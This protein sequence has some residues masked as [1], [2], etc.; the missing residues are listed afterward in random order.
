MI[1]VKAIDRLGQTGD[2]A[3]IDFFSIDTVP[4]G[5]AA[6][7]SPADDPARDS[8]VN[9]QTPLFDWDASPGDVFGYRLLVASGDFATGPVVIE[10]VITGD[11]T[12]FQVPT[13][14]AGDIRVVTGDVLPDGVY[15][16]RV[17]ARDEARNTATSDTRTFTVDL[18]APGAPVLVAPVNAPA[19]ESFLNTR[20]TFLE[21]SPST[22]DVFD[23][24]LQVT[25]GDID[26]GPFDIAK[27]IT[28][29]VT[30]GEIT[31]SGDGTYQWRVI[32][33]DKA[34]NAATS[35]T[36]IF[37]V[38]IVP[39][40]VPPLRAPA[41]GAFLKTGTPEFDWG[42]SAGDLEDYLLQ[43]VVSGEGFE[44]RPFAIEVVV[45]GDVTRFQV[46]TGDALADA[47]TEYKWR[48][49][50][51]DKAFN[52]ATSDTRTFTVDV[53]PPGTA[54]LISPARN[55]FLNSSTPPFVWQP[56]TEVVE[57]ATGDGVRTE[58][59]LDGDPADRIDDDVLTDADVLVE[60][61]IGTVLT[62]ITD[63][64]VDHTGDTVTFVVAPATGDGA[65]IRFTYSVTGD[66]TA[67]VQ[68]YRLQVVRSGDEF[69][70]GFFVINE[71]LGTKITDTGRLPTAAA[72]DPLADDTYRWRVTARD[73]SLNVT[74]SDART[75][76]VDTVD[77]DLPALVAPAQGAFVNT[78]TPLL[79]WAPI[80]VQ[81]A[82]GDGVKRTFAL[83]GDPVDRDFD[84]ILTDADVLVEQPIGILLT[85]TD[86]SVDHTGDTVTFVVAPGTGGTP[87]IVRF[88]FVI[89]DN[90]A[91][92]EDYLL[93]VTSG[94]GDIS[95]GPFEI[96]KEITGDTTQFQV[97]T[98]DA[99]TYSGRTYQWRVIARDKAFNAATSDTQVFVVDIVGPGAPPLVAPVNAPARGSFLNTST[100]LFVWNESDLEVKEYL[101]RVTSGDIN[102]GDVVIDVVI[103]T[104]D[105]TEFQV[106]TADP[107]ADGRYEWR[108]TARDRAGNTA[109][110]LDT[111]TFT[112]DTEAP[113][114]PALVAPAN[115]PVRASFLNTSTPLFDWAEPP[116]TG[117]VEDYLLQV[118]SGATFTAPFDIGEVISGDTTEFQVPAGTALPEAGTAYRWRVI[119]R[120]EAF[121]AGTS[122]IRTFT[123]DTDAPVPPE[124]VS[125]ADL[126]ATGSF[127]NTGGVFF[128]WSASQTP[129]D[130]EEYLLQV[131]LSGDE[132]RIGSFARFKTADA[133]TTELQLQTADLL[134][135]AAYEWRVVAQ[136]LA[137]NTASSVTRT[138]KVDTLPPSRPQNLEEVTVD[139]RA[140]ARVFEWDPSIDP[141][142]PPPG[143]TGDESG[144]KFYNVE[145]RG[146][147][148]LDIK[149][150]DP[151]IR[152]GDLVQFTTPPLVAGSYTIRVQA[153]DAAGNTGDFT[154][155][156]PFDA[157]PKDAVQNLRVVDP[158]FVDTVLG[159]TVS[160]SDPTFRWTRPRELDF[161][162]TTYLV[163]VTGDAFGIPFGPFTGDQFTVACFD[164]DG[165][166]LGT[167][168]QCVIAIDAGDETK[169]T[170]TG[171]VPDGTHKLGVV[172]ID[173]EGNSGPVVE[174]TFT[175]DTKAPGAPVLVVPADQ[176]PPEDP[177]R[178]AFLNTS[179]PFF[180]WNVSTGDVFGYRLRVTS[181]GIATGPV[182]VEVLITGD[183]TEFQLQPRDLAVTLDTAIIRI[184]TGD[185]LLDGVYQWQVIARDRALNLATSDPR[186]FTVDTVAPAPPALLRPSTVDLFNSLTVEFEWVPST[187]DDIFSYRLQVTSGDINLGPFDVDKELFHPT[188]GDRI[189]LSGDGVYQWRVGAQDLAGND[190][191]TGDLEVRSFEVD[192]VP[193][194]PP[195]LL[196]P[197]TGDRFNSR[198][199]EFE[200]APSTSDDIST[201]RLQVTSGDI[202]LGPFQVDKVLSHPTTGDRITLSG[203]EVYKWRVG[204]QDLAGN[205][206]PTGDLEV[207]VFEV[208]TVPPA[209]PALLRPETGDL[210]NSRTVEFEWVPST[211]DDIFSYRLQV[212]TADGDIDAGPL[213]VDKELLHPITGDGITVSGDGVYQWRVIARD[214]ALNTAASVTRTFTVDTTPPAAPA[215][216]APVDRAFENTS[217]PSFDWLASAST[218]DVFGYRLQ[219][220]RFTEASGLGT[221][222]IDVV[223]TGDVVTGDITGF[224]ALTGDST[225]IGVLIGGPL[226]DGRYE[227]HVRARDLAR[228]EVP[229]RDLEVRTFTVDTVPPP[230]PDLVSP[231]D[232]ALVRTRTPLFAWVPN[233]I[234]VSDN[235]LRV[236]SGDITTG[237][238]DLD[239]MV[240]HEILRFQTFQSTGDLADGT[241]RWRVTSRDLALN[242][243]TSDTRTFTVD[244]TPPAA[245]VLVAPADSAFLNTSTTTFRWATGDADD[246]LLQVVVAGDD[247]VKGPFAIS[248]VI[249]G[250][251]TE[252][253]V[254]TGDALAD[255]AYRWRVIAR[256]L[257]LNTASSVTRTFTV[258]T[259]P[260]G[261]PALVEPA[262]GAFLDTG[263]PAFDWKDSTG[264][265]QEYLLRVVVS[266][267]DLNTGP[268]AINVVVATAD[269]TQ[270]Q[271]PTGDA[272]NDATY[273]WRVTARDRALNTAPS[274]TR[275]FV[276]DTITPTRP[277]TAD[278]VT[279]DPETNQFDQNAVV[280]VLQWQRSTDPI[281][282]PPNGTT[283]DESGVNFYN[284]LVTGPQA[285]AGV[286]FHNTCNRGSTGDRCEFVTPEL[287][288]GNYEIRVTAVDT[289][290]N[291]SPVSIGVFRAGPPGVVR[292]L[293]LVAPVF[294]NTVAT[295]DP[296]FRWNPPEL[297][298]QVE[299][300]TYEVATGDPT[301]APGPNVE[302]TPFT[303]DNFFAECFN[304][305]GDSIGSGDEC[306]NVPQ[307][308]DI[309]L[310]INGVPDGTHALLVRGITSSSGGPLQ[311]STAVKLVFTVDTTPPDAP[312]LVTPVDA[313][314]RESFLNT[315]TPFLKWS[316]SSGDVFAYR[317][318]VTSGDINTGPFDVDKEILH[319]ITG[320]LIQLTGDET[321]RWRVIARDRALNVSTSDTRTFTLDTVAPGA[322]TNLVVSP[323]V[324]GDLLATSRPLFDWDE[325]PTTG[326]VEDY[327]L[328][329]ASGDLA[330]GPV[331]LE[332]VVTGDTTQFQPTGD[333]PDAVYE[334]IVIARDKALNTGASII[335]TFKLDTTPPGPAE[336]VSPPDKA[337]LDVSPAFFAWR[338][339]TGDVFRY[340]V[341][342]TSGDIDTGPFDIEKFLFGDPPAARFRVV[343]GLGT[344]DGRYD[345]R[346]V[347]SD[348]AGNAA[349]SDTE[350]F[351]L[352][353]TDP[354]KPRLVSLADAPALAS[355]LNDTTPLFDWDEV[356]PT[357]DVVAYL[358]QVVKS[359]DDFETGPFQI[360]ELVRGDVTQFQVQPGRALSTGGHKWRVFARERRR[361]AVS[362]IQT[363]TVDTGVPETPVL[364]FPQAGGVIN[365]RTPRFDWEASASEDIFSYRLQVAL[366]GNID[367]GP[368]AVDV[369]ITSGDPLNTDFQAA[370]DLPD[371]VYQWRVTAP[372]PGP[373]HRLL[374]DGYLYSGR[375]G[376]QQ[377]N[378]PT[379]NR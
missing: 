217:T 8:F 120:D 181:D 342:V 64:T 142:P 141:V 56:T 176:A 309:Q 27:D 295:S 96:E 70:P 275:T 31:L 119:A 274:V 323:V 67:D 6:L 207:R 93:Q 74:T 203:D 314:A 125:P 118:T 195:A 186:T 172:V 366:S 350:S 344:A 38:D 193:P 62:P 301:L 60:H 3:D 54:D 235:V 328:R 199:V 320:D 302:F 336:L 279:I 189:T 14:D 113:A 253:Q 22:G 45:T 319:P 318:R 156:L 98:G 365:T 346:V 131:V 223:I 5:A 300:I 10:V 247:L 194:A 234:F 277:G 270:F 124:L 68:D 23:Y 261:A 205:D 103:K 16:W 248:L 144:V 155:P 265:V 162:L 312:V 105:G 136:D 69:L 335:R 236:T 190:V 184:L 179:T 340:R 221:L 37:V 240:Q 209:P 370:G 134:D 79:D 233:T 114:A 224:L 230:E 271:V 86:Y 332:Q 285:V 256:D 150:G 39:P 280:R 338:A 174:V 148:D 204:S 99:L 268:F 32:A 160:T 260:P 77:P 159:G 237:P 307:T 153:E 306:I 21:W 349:T 90:A 360:Q 345:W 15:Q 182:V 41:D 352:D 376:T 291:V 146:T 163:A 40:G 378:G 298:P 185:A 29:P 81:T 249:T 152:S 355:F 20:T 89:A 373:E 292:N 242:P 231:D 225:R 121:N 238:F 180:D 129:A 232:S 334:W 200:W 339:S 245:P 48:V 149:T 316:P 170:I 116:T 71:K 331:V 324:T 24:R 66:L 310:T 104:A 122:D 80:R 215:L 82:A 107:L 201:Y 347:A 101:L 213:V 78:R 219:V 375:G 177:P 329:V 55:D 34:L 296:V 206:V 226:A 259:E 97:P 341:L 188:T 330:T 252:F 44:T 267:D 13:G 210:F 228:N 299:L 145:I 351:T 17:I 18:V 158:V 379:T 132:F 63:Y 371:A 95:E 255:A 229:R 269:G 191:L 283:G 2:P 167:G 133:L 178:E 109:D 273:R 311:P 108:V 1:T 11:I 140:F 284:V 102:T 171:D 92:V 288:P 202:N 361:F 83:T 147:G 281:P 138:F 72:L 333:L 59:D 250:D 362:D 128:D 76:T 85:T 357:G 216:V 168:D 286:V 26:T 115:A 154:D 293:R 47:G 367:S 317:L 52:A 303:G 214:K 123:V 73:K 368:F 183:A 322:P 9:T 220:A 227:W 278:D 326:D 58:F 112:V 287:V 12:Q 282:P 42:P 151:F 244:A 258:D 196:R 175:V 25:S 305:T 75:F 211:S 139:P 28:H 353:T 106:S 358:I 372:R 100:P 208:D 50:A 337:F 157:G 364:V 87:S 35:D 51:R 111:R 354:G 130:V 369:V 137:L 164:K 30:G 33:R 304:A 263:V 321:Y 289:A 239:V 241:Y 57:T 290:D 110:S 359:G 135:D 187:S 257:A 166:P 377:A 143:T 19:R 53:V 197:E 212:T 173:G 327:L 363:F 36:R 91:D 315:R 169:L 126:P 88:T 127:L 308:A 266:G 325:S 294:G 7:V 297:D 198:T 61:P 165:V 262:D 276:V 343:E 65:N 161:G 192:T 272:L 218:A 222:V 313:P 49:I 84:G 374:G 251:T 4:P 264:D 246:Y 243:A 46:P 356:A 348:K 43:V 117:D 94:S 254:P